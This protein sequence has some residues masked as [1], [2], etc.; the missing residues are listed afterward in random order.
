MV[1][2]YR[3]VNLETGES[4]IGQSKDIDKRIQKHMSDARSDNPP[5]NI[6]KALKL[7]GLNN[8]EIQVCIECSE[9]DLNYYERIFINYYN[10]IQDGY[11]I[12]EGGQD[13]IGNSNP[14]AKITEK[15]VFDIREAYKNHKRKREVYEQYKDKLTWMYFSNLWEGNSWTY[16]HMDV[17]TEDNIRYYSKEAT[18]GEN[19]PKAQFTNEEVLNI[20]QRYVNESAKSIY[21]DYKDRCKF[22]TFQ[23]ILWGRNYKELP[24]YDKRR[25]AWFKTS[26]M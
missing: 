4:Y 23:Q 12:L 22:Q 2:I 6:S 21:E 15:D 26:N 24:I 20:R 1:G 3:I 8:F 25:K 16:I 18:N 7:Y 10:S 17:Y 13:N 14:N 9:N 5:T 19:S 11:N